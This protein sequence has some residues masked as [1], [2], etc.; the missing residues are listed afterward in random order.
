MLHLFQSN[1]VHCSEMDYREFIEQYQSKVYQFAYGILGNREDADEIA[2]KVFVKVYFSVKR[3]DAAVFTRGSTALL[4]MSAMDF[5]ARNGSSALM[6]ATRPQ[7]QP[8]CRSLKTH[9]LNL[10][11]GG[12][13]YLTHCWSDCPRGIGTCCY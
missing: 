1:I 13:I 11:E 4:S 2:Q 6:R 3:L 7:T 12:G 10:I 9:V 8:R 5:C